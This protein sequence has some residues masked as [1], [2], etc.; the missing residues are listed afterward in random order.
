MFILYIKVS[1]IVVINVR[2]YR[3]E[4]G[5]LKKHIK[6]EHEG[7]KYQCDQCQQEF[8]SQTNLKQHILSV[9]EDIT[10]QFNKCIKQ[11]TQKQ[12]LNPYSARFRAN[13]HFE[14]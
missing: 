4:L 8:L 2:N 12:N 11:Y 3:T 1:T 14:L 5:F 9:H 13:F 7:V 6:S 10:Y